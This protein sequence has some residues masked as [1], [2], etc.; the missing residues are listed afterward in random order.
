M[1]GLIFDSMLI[2]FTEEKFEEVST[3]LGERRKGIM[4]KGGVVGKTWFI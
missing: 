2:E 3:P 1:S 4:N